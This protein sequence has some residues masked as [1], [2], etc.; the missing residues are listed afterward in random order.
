MLHGR[1]L[2]PIRRSPSSFDL[3]RPSF[4]V[5]LLFYTFRYK[6]GFLPAPIERS[7][8]KQKV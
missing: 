3:G 4:P 2:C 5:N 6:P 8:S 1:L 7:T